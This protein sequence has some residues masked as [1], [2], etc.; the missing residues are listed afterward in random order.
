[1]IG[2]TYIHTAQYEE[3]EI[4]ALVLKIPVEKLKMEDPMQIL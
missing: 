2:F 3:R 4:N 1:M